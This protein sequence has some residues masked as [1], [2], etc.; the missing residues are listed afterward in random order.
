MERPPREG[1]EQRGWED[2]LEKIV[3]SFLV[4]KIGIQKA[5]GD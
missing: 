1:I 2:G 5:G 4:C 3:I